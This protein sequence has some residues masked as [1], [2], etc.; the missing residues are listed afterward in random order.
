LS[1]WLFDR[2]TFAGG[3]T[4]IQTSSLLMPKPL[5]D[6]YQFRS[7]M[8][9]DEWDMLFRATKGGTEIITVPEVLVRYYTGDERMSL[10]K[11]HKLELAL[12]WINTE[13]ET[14]TPKAYS[15]FCLTVAAQH[16]KRGGA[17]GDF[18]HLLWLAFRY[19]A[20]TAMQLLVYLA[21]W[22]V[23][24]SAGREFRRFVAARRR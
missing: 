21:V 24:Q 4:F 18:V 5:F 13:R 15:G 20:P 12:D 2:R 22:V 19:G 8:E 14:F 17:I 11:S 23:P 9:H 7:P 16:A 1:E 10:S 6:K 3:E